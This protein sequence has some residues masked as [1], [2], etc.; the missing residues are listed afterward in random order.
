MKFIRFIIKLNIFHK[1]ELLGSNGGVKISD[2]NIVPSL[3]IYPPAW[4]QAKNRVLQTSDIDDLASAGRS[5]I[6]GEFG[7]LPSGSTD[8]ASIVK[9]AKSKGYTV[10]GWAWNGDGAY[11]MN[12]VRRE[13]SKI[14]ELIV[15]KF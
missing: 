4:D 6:I 12:M 1:F 13:I 9:Y 14:Y 5:L 11:G 2:S 10:L 8:W 3:H 15:F 7:S